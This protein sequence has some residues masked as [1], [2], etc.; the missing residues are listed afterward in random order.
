MNDFNTA[1]SATWSSVIQ[2]ITKQ[3]SLFQAR[4]VNLFQRSIIVYT[5]V[6]SKVWYISQ[7]YPLSEK[8]AK[9][10]NKIVFPYIWNSSG[11]PLK[12]NVI[13]RDKKA[14]GINVFNVY[15]IN[16]FG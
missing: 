10:I 12:R 11:E 3:V 5:L 8:V 6:Q 4:K 7:T 9:S 2:K 1:V 14:G 13:Y 15:L 16:L